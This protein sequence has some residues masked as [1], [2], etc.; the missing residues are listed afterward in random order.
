VQ[1]RPAPSGDFLGQAQVALELQPNSWAAYP[2]QQAGYQRQCL[3]GLY[4]A[5]L[6]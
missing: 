5:R 4:E 6:P 2:L 1:T 3:L